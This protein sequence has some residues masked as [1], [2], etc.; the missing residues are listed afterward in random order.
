M[1]GIVG[2]IS[3]TPQ[4]ISK[5][6]S[7]FFEDLLIADSVRGRD[8]TGV[9]KVNQKGESLF[10]KKAGGPFELFSS[11]NYN[12]FHIKQ[13][14]EKITALIGHNR[15]GTTG[16]AL[17]ECAH[18]FTFGNITMVHNGTLLRHSPL[19][20]FMQFRTDSEALCSAIN[21]LGIQDTIKK[22]WGSF[23]IVY[24]NAQDNTINFARNEHR[25]LFFCEIVKDTSFAF[26]SEDDMLAWFI[27]RHFPDAHQQQ[28]Y[29]LV[30][31]NLMTIALS[32]KK[33]SFTKLIS[34]IPPVEKKRK[35][36]KSQAGFLT[37][38]P[39]QTPITD[40]SVFQN[41]R[42]VSVKCLSTYHVEDE[43][44]FTLD[45]IKELGEDENNKRWLIT[46]R[47]G[48]LE[49][50]QFRFICKSEQ[51]KTDL[52]TGIIIVGKI[53][54]IRYDM[55]NTNTADKKEHIMYVSDC[56]PCLLPDDTTDVIG[57]FALKKMFN[58][59]ENMTSPNAKGTIQ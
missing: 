3:V 31:Y 33:V 27:K 56:Q 28:I 45:T 22:V 21:D 13:Q 37:Q 10:L 53:K 40:A 39:I 16:S 20:K 54:H 5:K 4:G 35:Q 58:Y 14:N 55:T 26:A 34:H 15:F 6:E 18:P 47:R 36:N 11:P 12:Q 19:P 7:Q 9:V 57:K 25:P 51:N 8:G 29:D 48:D 43:I 44:I 2:Y 52:E 42:Y 24:F 1:C 46:G 17:T 30:P 50:I 59:I 23:S 41:N 49:G 38:T 32:S